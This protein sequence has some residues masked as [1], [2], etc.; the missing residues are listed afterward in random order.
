MAYAPRA[1]WC[2][3]AVAFVL[4]SVTPAAAG[5]LFFVEYEPEPPGSLNQ[6]LRNVNDVAVSPDG[7]NL[8]TASQ[9]EDSI[10]VFTRDL[11][12]GAVTFLEVEEDGVGGVD[13]LRK[14]TG[15]A[16]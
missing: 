12:T 10:G 13:G 8:Y 15:V 3:A 1:G 7:E 5:G 16:V 11:G 2:A 14:A 4:W 9:T 6:A